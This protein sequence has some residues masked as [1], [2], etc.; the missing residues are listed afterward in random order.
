MTPRS[1]T[2]NPSGAASRGCIVASGQAD[3][4]LVGVGVAALPY[5]AVG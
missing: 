5:S 1:A 3:G 4:E 2:L